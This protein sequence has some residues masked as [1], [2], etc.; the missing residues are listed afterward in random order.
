[1]FAVTSAPA[2]ASTSAGSNPPTSYIFAEKV[3]VDHSTTPIHHV[4]LGALLLVGAVV[5]IGWLNH[6]A[7]H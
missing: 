3:N 2:S 1:M 7:N 6:R 5:A 4:G